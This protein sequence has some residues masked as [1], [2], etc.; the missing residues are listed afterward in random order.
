MTPAPPHPKSS[1][2]GVFFD[3]VPEPEGNN[4]IYINFYNAG[5]FSIE[6]SREELEKLHK[7]LG[8][9]IGR[10]SHTIIPSERDKVL[11][12]FTS[13]LMERCCNSIVD[14]EHADIPTIHLDELAGIIKE[15]RTT[16]R[17]IDDTKN[18]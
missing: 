8:D 12:E 15:L 9:F 3:I 2:E 10:T 17:R 11:D 16:P 4:R 14:I 13:I 18:R 7:R 5:T 1:G 6:V